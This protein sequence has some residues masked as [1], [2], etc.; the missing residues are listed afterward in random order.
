MNRTRLRAAA[1]HLKDED[2]QDRAR[3]GTGHVVGGLYR[4][5]E[6]G[7]TYEVVDRATMWVLAPDQ[8]ILK[9][10]SGG[11]TYVTDAP[12]GSDALVGR[13]SASGVDGHR[14]HHV[15]EALHLDP[16]CLAAF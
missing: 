2:G 10:W 13:R 15:V 7:R 8:A 9:R 5:R 12:V 3:T 11:E 14:R 1:E 16:D 4:C 6:S